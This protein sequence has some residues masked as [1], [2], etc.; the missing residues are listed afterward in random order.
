MEAALSAAGLAAVELAEA[1]ISTDVSEDN[2]GAIS[3]GIVA[4]GGRLIRHRA[5]GWARRGFGGAE[6]LPNRGPGYIYRIGS[7]SKSVTVVGLMSL[8]EEG[9]PAPR[10]RATPS[11]GV[12]GVLPSWSGSDQGSQG[13]PSAFRGQHVALAVLER[14]PVPHADLPEIVAE[15]L[16]IITGRGRRPQAELLAPRAPA[17]GPGCRVA[18]EVRH[19][20]VLPGVACGL[21]GLR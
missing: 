11:P 9:V 17:L 12:Q 8:V 20:D 5:F 15:D 6:W 10:L 14:A 4:P 7:I 19:L 21:R 13:R 2:V 18:H 3:L 16:E 1:Q